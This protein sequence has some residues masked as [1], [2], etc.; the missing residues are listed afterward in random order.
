MR[1]KVRFKR[2]LKISSFKLSNKIIIILII[3]LLLIVFIIRFINMRFNP[4]LLDYASLE[5]RKLSS[6]II[7]NAVSKNVA[8]DIDINELFL[9]TKDENNQIKTIDFNPITINKILTKTTS[10][11]QL[12]LKYIEQGKIEFLNLQDNALIDY[13]VDK[14]KQGIIYE[15]PS[16]VVLGNSFLANIGPKIPVRFNLVGDI[17]SYINTK[18]SDYG[19]NNALI[20][21]NLVLE[22]SEQVILPFVTD[23]ITIKTSIPIAL[24]LVQGTVPEYYLNG[25]DE[26]SNSLSIPIE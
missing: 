3:L 12:D 14:L 24:K 5:S 1:R 7:N 20:E 6:I 13:D 10:S 9:I 11:V 16:G 18:I 2:R 26:N 4:V 25:I 22:L 8:Q 23:K 17:V 15:I 19:I 21:V